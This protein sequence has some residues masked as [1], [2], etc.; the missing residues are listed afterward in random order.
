[1][2]DTSAEEA[3]HR[4]NDNWQAEVVPAGG[5]HLEQRRNKSPTGLQ[6]TA[7]AVA[8]AVPP[9]GLVLAAGPVSLQS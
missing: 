8:A 1:M 9:K 4:R 3:A 5:S 2:A 6:V 7:M